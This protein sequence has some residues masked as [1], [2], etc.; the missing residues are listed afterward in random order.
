M[1]GRYASCAR[2]SSGQCGKEG[3]GMIGSARGQEALG[4]QDNGARADR[5]FR[6]R[7]CLLEAVNPLPS[8]HSTRNSHESFSENADHSGNSIHR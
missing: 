4:A 1:P 7:F 5:K 3:K 8:S 6:G 2:C